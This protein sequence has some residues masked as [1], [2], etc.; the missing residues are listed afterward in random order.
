MVVASLP[1]F[2]GSIS[3]YQLY[4]QQK[5]SE[6]ER[7]LDLLDFGEVLLIH[8]INV[9]ENQQQ[10]IS[11]PLQESCRKSGMKFDMTQSITR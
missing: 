9:F 4:R 5:R 6:G 10:Q 3:K 1:G 11:S 2:F 7:K 8:I